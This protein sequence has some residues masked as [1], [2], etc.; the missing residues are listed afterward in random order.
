MEHFAAPK[1]FNF[2]IRNDY[3]NSG[4]IKADFDL[5]TIRKRMAFPAGIGQTPT[6]DKAEQAGQNNKQRP[7][8][9]K[10]KSSSR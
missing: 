5:M 4:F 2:S 8:V 7:I 6:D 9:H 10:C 3:I 1:D